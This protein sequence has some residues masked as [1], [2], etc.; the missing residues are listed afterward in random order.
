MRAPDVNDETLRDGLQSPSARIPELD[1]KIA[2]LELMP[3]IGVNSANLGFPASS[4]REYHDVLELTRTVAA[5]RLPIAPNCAARTIESDIEPVADISQR[6]GLAIEV[7]LFIGSSPIRQLVEGWSMDH[8]CRTVETCVASA[9]RH[10]LPVMFVT[11]DT[12]RSTPET[13]RTLCRAAVDQGAR[14]VCVC[15]TVGSAAPAGVRRL[16]SFVRGIVGDDVHI[17]WHGHND[18]GLALANSIEAIAAGADRVHATALGIGERV[19]NCSLE[20]LLMTVNRLGYR[21]TDL[22]KL[23]DYLELVSQSVGVPIPRLPVELRDAPA[24]VLTGAD[25]D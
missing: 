11:E 6:A 12:F 18:R 8:L 21:Q 16:L 4:A 9:V 23:E 14:R 2:I 25:P 7:D 20:Q 17:D 1:R 24:F 22:S 19:G 13:I 3:A 10:N 15:D 5:R